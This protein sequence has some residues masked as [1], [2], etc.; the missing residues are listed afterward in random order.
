MVLPCTIWCLLLIDDPPADSGGGGGGQRFHAPLTDQPAAV[1]REPG[2]VAA[3]TW[4]ENHHG[5]SQPGGR[6]EQ[7]PGL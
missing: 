1:L 7:G 6:G 5:S 3:A 2:R 4:Q